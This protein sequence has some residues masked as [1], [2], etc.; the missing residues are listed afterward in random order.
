MD[1]KIKKAIIRA[2][3]HG[4]NIMEIALCFCLH[5]DK[6]TYKNYLAFCEWAKSNEEFYY[7]L[8]GRLYIKQ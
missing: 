6:V 1:I 8:V 7:W 5:K 3:K 2:A 4:L